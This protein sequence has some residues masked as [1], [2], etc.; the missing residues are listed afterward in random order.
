MKYLQKQT[1]PKGVDLADDEIILHVEGTMA[2]QRV[3]RHI[4]K[5]QAGQVWF[6][7]AISF[8]GMGTNFLT[9]CLDFCR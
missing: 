9:E 5:K 4:K 8:R 6:S 3:V 7:C 2:S 1:K